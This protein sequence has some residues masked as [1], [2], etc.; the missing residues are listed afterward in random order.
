M[1]AAHYCNSIL[2]HWFTILVSKGLKHFT[3]TTSLKQRSKNHNF[4]RD[5]IKNFI[6]SAF[7]KPTV[8]LLQWYL[9]V[10]VVSD[11][12]LRL[13]WDQEVRRHHASSWVEQWSALVTR[14]INEFTA[15]GGA[16]DDRSV[17]F[18]LMD[19]L[20]EGVL[21]IGSW[22]SP[23]DRP[24]VVVYTFPVIS[25]V[26]PIWLHVTLGYKRLSELCVNITISFS[27]V[28]LSEEP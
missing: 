7:F 2:G 23:H 17:T 9:V 3:K 28:S 19:E 10:Q 1:L 25:D 26:F 20:V 24:S 8:L 21:P 16:N 5:T 22:L 13:S 6:I 27:L 18:T 15:P 4:S 11:G 14:V 12:M